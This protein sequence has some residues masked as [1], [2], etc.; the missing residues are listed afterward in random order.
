METKAKHCVPCSGDVPALNEKEEDRYMEDL[1][2]WELDRGDTH[3]ISKTFTFSDFRE[4]VN[5]VNQVAAL[6][7]KEEHHPDITI[8]Y[9]KVGI[10]LYTHKIGGLHQNDFIM[11]EKLDEL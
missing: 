9:N 5:F 2:G 7:N 1:S 11:A 4:A 10:T 6:A 8:N 3:T